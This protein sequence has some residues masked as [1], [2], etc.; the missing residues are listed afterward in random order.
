MRPMNPVPFGPR[1]TSARLGKRNNT[2][3]SRPVSEQVFLVVPVDQRRVVRLVRTL[4]SGA[5]RAALVDLSTSREIKS[6]PIA[7]R[8]REELERVARL[9][10]GFRELLDQRAA[11]ARATAQAMRPPEPPPAPPP[12]PERPAATEPEESFAPN[13]ADKVETLARHIKAVQVD[14]AKRLRAEARGRPARFPYDPDDVLTVE[15]GKGQGYWYIRTRYGG[16]RWAIDPKSMLVSPMNSKGVMGTKRMDGIV[17]QTMGVP[18]D[19][20]GLY[21][22]ASRYYIPPKL[23]TP[24]AVTWVRSALAPPPPPP[25]PK[26]PGQKRP[27]RLATAPNLD[28][29]AWTPTY[30]LSSGS[31]A[32]RGDTGTMRDGWEG[33]SYEAT[34]GMGIAQIAALIRSDIKAAIDAGALPPMELSIKS[35]SFANGQSIDVVIKRIDAG[36]ELINPRWVQRIYE[37]EEPAYIGDRRL[38][39]DGEAVLKAVEEIHRKYNRDTSDIATDYFNVRYYGDVKFGDTLLQQEKFNALAK[40]GLMRRRDAFLEVDLYRVL[41]DEKLLPPSGLEIQAAE[42][43]NGQ[44]LISLVRADRNYSLLGVSP[45]PPVVISEIETPFS[46]VLEVARSLSLEARSLA[47][48]NGRASARSFN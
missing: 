13:F 36:I 29:K 16:R 32:V 2:A 47:K 43:G 27:I 34:Q 15:P 45:K 7:R 17:Y 24:R 37:G 19:D 9:V 26:A 42:Q 5:V 14:D 4:A 12:E 11:E 39:P 1:F 10:V 3:D 8:T 48:K 18:L 40:L 31:R 38:T 28:R 33:G 6:F 21:D 22:W 23:A 35:D 25:V 20:M 41:R 30:A 44:W 46:D